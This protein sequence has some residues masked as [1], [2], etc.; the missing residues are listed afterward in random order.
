MSKS[1]QE[2]FGNDV[3]RLMCWTYVYRCYSKKLASIK[4]VS[5]DLAMKVD[6]DLHKIQWMCQIEEKFGVVF[7]LL[8]DKFLLGQINEQEMEKLTEFFD[9]FRKQWGPGSHVSK[10]YEGAHPFHPGHN[11]GLERFNRTAKDDFSYREQLDMSQFVVVIKK[12]IEHYSEKD[13]SILDGRRLLIL[14]KDQDGIKDK[15][16]FKIQE[17]GYAYFQEN[18]KRL[19]ST[20]PGERDFLRPGKQLEINKLDGLLLLS[21]TAGL[22][23]KRVIILP[24]ND[25]KLPE[26]SLKEL[27]LLRLQNRKKPSFFN[28][29]EY[30]N[31]R[32]SCHLI[33]QVDREF[34][35][36]CWKGIKGKICKHVMARVQHGT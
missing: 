13:Y 8:E 4:K 26:K 35:Y 34:Q 17:V 1:L 16:S 22:D 30:F 31:I 25:N 3:V 32:T 9:Y 20:I 27:A 2:V 15:D 14:Q 11:Q 24:S 29:Q 33:E 12:M 6:N 23:V 5:K 21:Q 36:D 10:W 19:P 18:L 7:Q 28:I